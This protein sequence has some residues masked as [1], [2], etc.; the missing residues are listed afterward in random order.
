MFASFRANSLIT[1]TTISGTPYIIR[2]D[3]T[4][5]N[6]RFLEYTPPGVKVTELTIYPM[7]TFQISVSEYYQQ[8][9]D[10][11][12]TS[13]TAWALHDAEGTIIETDGTSSITWDML[14]IPSGS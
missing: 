10:L 13:T 2:N 6:A 3:F 5:K 8:I 4:V 11:S 1:T 7:V 12:D 14:V 9:E